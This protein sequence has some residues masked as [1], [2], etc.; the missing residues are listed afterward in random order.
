MNQTLCKYFSKIANSL[1]PTQNV[2]IFKKIKQE[3]API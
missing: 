2:K 3:K 1:K